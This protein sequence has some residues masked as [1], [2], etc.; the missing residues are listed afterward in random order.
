MKGSWH[1]L[2]VQY[3][4]LSKAIL[5]VHP[6]TNNMATIMRLW[7]LPLDYALAANGLVT[8]LMIYH[9]K[10]FPLHKQ[11]LKEQNND[12]YWRRSR[13]FGPAYTLLLELE[14]DSG[15]PLFQYKDNRAKPFIIKAIAAVQLNTLWHD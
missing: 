6:S 14:R 15:I 2:A 1:V 9:D 3:R 7:E 4:K 13:F 12:E 5:G 8:F 10:S 11:M